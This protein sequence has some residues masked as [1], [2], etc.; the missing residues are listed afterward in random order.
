MLNG[1]KRPVNE[2]IE[3]QGIAPFFMAGGAKNCPSHAPGLA[4]E[5]IFMYAET[6]RTD[7]MLR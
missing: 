4:E 1:F 6:R 3:Q 5:G 7:V 2:L